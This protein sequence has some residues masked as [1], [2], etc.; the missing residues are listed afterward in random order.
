MSDANLYENY[1]QSIHIAFRSV[2]EEV[3]LTGIPHCV[4]CSYKA[5]DE[6]KLAI[7][8]KGDGNFKPLED[9]LLS[10]Q[11]I[12]NQ[13]DD[14]IQKLQ[15]DGFQ[16][17]ELTIV[18]ETAYGFCWR[19]DH[20]MAKAIVPPPAFFLEN[21]ATALFRACTPA[22]WRPGIY[23]GKSEVSE[24][25][26]LGLR[27]VAR[28]LSV[29][30]GAPDCP[31][32]Q[33]KT[34]TGAYFRESLYEQIQALAYRP[35]EER[36]LEGISMMAAKYVSDDEVLIHLE[37]PVRLS[38]TKP[39]R[40]SLDIAKGE[41]IILLDYELG[42]GVRIRGLGCVSD[43][44][45]KKTLTIEF[46]KRGRWQVRN[47]DS[48]IL[49]VVDGR[50]AFNKR[51]ETQLSALDDLKISLTT[52]IRKNLEVLCKKILDDNKGAILVVS[53]EAVSEAERLASRS[54]PI[55]PLPF[56]RALRVLPSMCKVDGAILLDENL[57]CHS[58]GAIL[59]GVFAPGSGNSG[60]GSRFN[61]AE[62]YALTR[63]SEG[64]TV[65]AMVF[66]ADGGMNI[67]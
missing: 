62:S 11:D 47:H 51:I 14:D 22:L 31:V 58:F 18:S 13:F 21:L 16:F 25:W 2:L 45:L 44:S 28:W 4:F 42:H 6:R 54:T 39:A 9:S 38:E 50:P 12:G 37:R 63:R 29:H 64:A 30:F 59:D 46:I 17:A 41:G 20:A 5:G 48:L 15:S 1:V 40:K 10:L 36:Y 60:R 67:V 32:H 66:S 53:F 43:L 23:L 27:E 56:D 8:P 52:D 33:Q 61:S 24:L 26:G 34:D 55:S 3:G 65:V 49:D 57:T 19:P 7:H 35:E